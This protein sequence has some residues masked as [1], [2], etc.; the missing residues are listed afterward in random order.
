ME[1]VLPW[2][3][4]TRMSHVKLYFLGN[5]EFS[6]FWVYRHSN[7]L[8][9]VKQL[10]STNLYIISWEIVWKNRGILRINK[11]SVYWEN[12]C[13]IYMYICIDCKQVSDMFICEFFIMHITQSLG[14]PGRIGPQYPLLVV[15]GDEMGGPSND[16]A[17]T[18]APCHSRCDAY[19]SFPVYSSFNTGLGLAHLKAH[20]AHLVSERLFMNHKEWRGDLCRRALFLNFKI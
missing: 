18:G 14:I 1:R 3:H 19:R 6:R 4:F 12:E 7:S 11:Y 13:N 10:Y 15:Q 2:G 5:E 20:A 16:S 8:N 17:K 9:L